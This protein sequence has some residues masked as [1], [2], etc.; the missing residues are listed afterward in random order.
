MNK[1]VIGVCAT[2]APARDLA[3]EAEPRIDAE[4]VIYRLEEA[5][6]ALLSLPNTGFTTAMRQSNLDLVR[7]AVEGYGWT[8][9]QIRPPLPT[10][11]QITRMDEALGWM[12]LIPG[13]R[14]VLRRIVGAR[15]LVSPITERYLY[16]WRRLAA[17][18]GADHKAVQRWHL[19]GVELIAAALNRAAGQ[20]ALLR[21]R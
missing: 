8:E 2:M 14:Y 5:G 12:S 1:T 17:L 19:Q 9:R 4:F 18:L 16:S 11:E 20:P 13:D 3:G 21:R 7:A 10:A 6:T 15:S